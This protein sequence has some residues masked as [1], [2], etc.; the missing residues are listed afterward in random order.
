MHQEPREGA[1]Q[2]VVCAEKPNKVE[3]SLRYKSSR[4]NAILEFTIVQSE[5][6]SVEGTQ[7]RADDPDAC[8]H[9]LKMILVFINKIYRLA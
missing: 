2:Y 4:E 6:V 1:Q 8:L 9:F 3:R 5:E 7:H